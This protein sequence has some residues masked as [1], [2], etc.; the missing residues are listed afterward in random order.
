MGP[1]RRVDIPEEDWSKA[2]SIDVVRH[3]CITGFKM[4]G[5]HSDLLESERGPSLENLDEVKNLNGTIYVRFV[6]KITPTPAHSVVSDESD[7]N[8][9][10]AVADKISSSFHSSPPAKQV[11]PK[12]KK[13]KVKH[14]SISSSNT[15]S[16]STSSYP[17][18]M[19]VAS[20]LKLG[21]VVKPSKRE[22]ILLQV[23]QFKVTN[24]WSMARN[25]TFSVEVESFAEGGFRKACR[26][27]SEDK[28]FPGLWVLKRYSEK[29]MNDM[30]DV[31][32][33][34]EDHARKQVQMHT[35][36]QN[37]ANQ[38][39]KYIDKEFGEP[40][41]Y[42]DMYLGKIMSTDNAEQ[43]FVTIEKYIEGKFIKYVNNNGNV[44]ANMKDVTTQKAEAL[45]HFSYQMSKGE[46][47][48]VD[49]QGT[50]YKLYDPE[51]AS[52]ILV[53]TAGGNS[54]INFCIGNLSITAIDS[55]FENHTCN[56]YCKKLG[57]KEDEPYYVTL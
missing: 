8:E 50:G 27:E 53:N 18:S 35:L 4:D 45:V 32:V 54:S 56:F 49:I 38:M 16:S 24:G 20:M 29:A 3:A 10:S 26:C 22:D 39:T 36:A 5:F 31:A 43:G 17:A 55:F 1:L 52:T 33:E 13:V 25:I 41:S 12:P 34:E 28:S 11:G 44:T 42:D 47:L 57:L 14:H 6:F 9:N 46:F 2:P 7:E 30:K 19:S 21:T 15:A 23:E 51:I 40:F 37:I 48:L